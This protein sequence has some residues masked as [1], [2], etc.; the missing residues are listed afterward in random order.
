[1]AGEI[2]VKA[3]L[4]ASYA[5]AFGSAVVDR[6]GFHIFDEILDRTVVS[7]SD[8]DPF[9]PPG[10]IRSPRFRIRHIDRVVF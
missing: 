1:M 6:R 4:F 10:L 3:L 7:V 5:D 8:A 9:F 2:E